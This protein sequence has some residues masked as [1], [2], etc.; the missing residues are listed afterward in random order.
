MLRLLARSPFEEAA[1]VRISG[2]LAAELESCLTD[3]VRYILER[4]V[5][6]ARFVETLRTLPLSRSNPPGLM[7]SRS[8]QQGS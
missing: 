5:R 4:D 1:R 2:Q 8:E 6:S 3:Y 7:P